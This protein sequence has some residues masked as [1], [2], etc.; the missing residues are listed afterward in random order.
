MSIFRVSIS[1]QVF[2]RF[3]E[4][5]EESCP[6]RIRFDENGQES[7]PF[8]Q[9][10]A[11]FHQLLMIFR[12]N[13]K[14]LVKFREKRENLTKNREIANGTLFLSFQ[15]PVHPAGGIAASCSTCLC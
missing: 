10:L 13:L 8:H 3:D 14:I 2:V 11:I 4:N 12:R 9:N 15:T 5:G 7:C 6:F 1:C